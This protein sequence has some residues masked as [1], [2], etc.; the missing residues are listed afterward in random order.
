M[1]INNGGTIMKRLY[2]SVLL[3]SI[4]C[5]SGCN[6]N[7]TNSNNLGGLSVEISNVGA[8]TVSENSI[9]LLAEPNEDEEPDKEETGT[10][11]KL[12]DNMY[13]YEN[14]Y[15]IVAY[16]DLM[17]M[18]EEVPE[19]VVFTYVNDPRDTI[20]VSCLN[21]EDYD[22]NELSESYVTEDD[23]KEN[24]FRGENVLGEQE[25]PSVNFTY[26]MN[27]IYYQSTLFKTDKTIFI[28][29]AKAVIPDEETDEVY[30]QDAAFLDIF[31]SIVIK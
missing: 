6:T 14:S 24:F 12:D 30:E 22:Y 3:L 21:S 26:S 27:D 20:T 15:Y 28:I 29:N 13:Q 8:S 9:E 25:I 2:T 5:L 10:V 31:N 19:Y 18:H 11:T 23:Y 17:S 4:L 1:C 16:S 7:A